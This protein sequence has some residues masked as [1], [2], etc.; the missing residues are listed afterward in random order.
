MATIPVEITW[1]TGQVVTAAQLNSNLRD[2]VNFLLSW[3]VCELRQT[4]AQSVANNTDTPLSMDAE[5][6]DTDNMHST[7]TNTS[8]VTAQTA[9]R[10]QLSGGTSYASNT[11]GRRA[12]SYRL[13]GAPML[14]TQAAITAAGATAD[15]Q[16]TGRT[17]TTYLN[18]GDYVEL[19]AYQDSGGSLNTQVT[20][21]QQPRFSVRM[22]GTT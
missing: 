14:G 7:V 2:A 17:L 5:E 1:T 15:V 11:T 18:V 3:P 12:A 13:N 8:R 4:V 20:T 16:P 9:G 19:V 22:V 10:F 6:I 21:G